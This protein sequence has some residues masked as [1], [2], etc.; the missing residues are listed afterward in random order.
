MPG[1]R[2]DRVH[3]P[4]DERHERVLQPRAPSRRAARAA[5]EP[6]ALALFRQHLHFD[7]AGFGRSRSEECVAIVYSYPG[8]SRSIW[9]SVGNLRRK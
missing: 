6:H 4:R 3:E 5:L 9:E 8:I 2:E 7:F 1:N